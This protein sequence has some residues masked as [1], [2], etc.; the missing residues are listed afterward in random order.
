MLDP[1]N[2]KYQINENDKKIK[3]FGNNFVINNKDKCKL[4][5]EDSQYILMPYF[6]VNILKN[7][8]VLELKL[9]II[10][11]ILDLSYMFYE[12]SS[13]LSIDENF[14]KIS[15]KITKLNSIFNGCSSLKSLPDISNWDL[16][17]AIDLSY[18]FKGCSS[19]NILPDISNWNTINAKTINLIAFVYR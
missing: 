13:L 4:M 5:F 15:T 3:I 11:E 19:L 12:C 7:K 1:I 17:N 9:E 2:L 10:D 14:S 16:N 6:E 18:L 8:K